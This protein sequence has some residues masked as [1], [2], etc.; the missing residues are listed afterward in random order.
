MHAL[1]PPPCDT[2][3][4]HTA[5]NPTKA[6]ARGMIV[7]GTT[8][9]PL[10]PLTTLWTLNK[11]MHVPLGPAFPSTLHRPSRCPSLLSCIH[12]S[13]VSLFLCLSVSHRLS[14]YQSSATTPLDNTLFYPN[15]YTLVQAG[16]APNRIPRKKSTSQPPRVSSHSGPIP[17]VLCLTRRHPSDMFAS[18]VLAALPLLSGKWSSAVERECELTG[19][20][21][22]F[23]LL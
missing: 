22:W 2:C 23:R 5:T 21:T 9:F 11:S 8:P 7:C 16:P 1:A 14:K 10:S 13:T 4:R 6:N 12:R 3:R 15:Q 18:I 20:P 17:L 19:I